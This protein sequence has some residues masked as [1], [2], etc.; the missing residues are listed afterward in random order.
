MAIT[1]MYCFFE[2]IFIT[3]KL[4]DAELLYHTLE[5]IFQ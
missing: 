5:R 1:L 3:D 4:M 2:S